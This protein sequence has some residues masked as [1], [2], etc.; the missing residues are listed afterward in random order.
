MRTALDIVADKQNGLSKSTANVEVH[1]LVAKLH[2]S[3]VYRVEVKVGGQVLHPI[4]HEIFELLHRG[5]CQLL[6]L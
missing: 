2:L 5:Q 1:A 3:K 6:D 4:L